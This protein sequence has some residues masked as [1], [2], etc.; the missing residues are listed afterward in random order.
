MKTTGRVWAGMT[1]LL[2]AGLTVGLL[3]SKPAQAAVY[4]VAAST[5]LK[6]ATGIHCAIPGGTAVWQAGGYQ[7]VYFNYRTT[8][9]QTLIV[10]SINKQ[11]YWT[12]NIKTDYLSLIDSAGAHDREL[13]TSEVRSQQNMWEFYWAEMYGSPDVTNGNGY[14]ISAVTN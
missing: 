11:N 5:C 9:A 8:S 1:F 6:W 3:R 13:V 14:G 12:G 7:T 10:T 2:A 4:T